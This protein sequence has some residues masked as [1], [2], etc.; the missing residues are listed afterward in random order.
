[1]VGIGNTK[2]DKTLSVSSKSSQSNERTVTDNTIHRDK[3]DVKGKHQEHET[4]SEGTQTIGPMKF[5]SRGYLCRVLRVSG[6]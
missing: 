2:I 3:C 5:L 4:S 1:M 6:C